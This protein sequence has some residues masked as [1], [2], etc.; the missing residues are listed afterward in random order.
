MLHPP[1]CGDELSPYLPYR[2]EMERRGLDGA[3]T[4]ECR[5]RAG[6]ESACMRQ[7]APDHVNGNE[8][9]PAK[10]HSWGR[11]CVGSHSGKAAPLTGR[12]ASIWSTPRVG[13]GHLGPPR[14][15]VT[16]ACARAGCAG[17]TENL[18]R[19]RTAP[20]TAGVVTLSFL[21][22]QRHYWSGGRGHFRLEG[23]RERT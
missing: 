17:R 22:K 10:R 15:A 3:G 18:T 6:T 4:A 20:T 16:S 1:R 9:R 2:W 13:V 8:V 21:V 14:H 5:L 7:R 12:A 11:S 19:F 23:P